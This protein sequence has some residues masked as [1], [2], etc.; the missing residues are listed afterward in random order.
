[1]R[2]SPRHG[3]PKPEYRNSLRKLKKA[4]YRDM[5]RAIVQAYLTQQT[6]VILALS[7]LTKLPEDFPQKQ[8]VAREGMVDYWKVRASRLLKWLNDNG[9]SDVTAESMRQALIRFT[10]NTKE[11]SLDI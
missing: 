10:H 3:R 4:D 1:M 7:Y 8:I 11:L 5:E 9:H 2:I 6:H